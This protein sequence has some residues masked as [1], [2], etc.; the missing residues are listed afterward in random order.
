MNVGEDYVELS[1][2]RPFVSEYNEAESGLDLVAR[3]HKEV[4]LRCH[5]L[6]PQ[7]LHYTLEPVLN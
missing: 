3:L 4:P 2:L 5:F 6:T 7:A 1:D